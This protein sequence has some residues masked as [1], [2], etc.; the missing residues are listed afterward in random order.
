MYDMN[1]EMKLPKQDKEG[2]WEKRGERGERMAR[3]GIQGGRMK[4]H[5]ISE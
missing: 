1:V 3:V 5:Y 2:W 4:D